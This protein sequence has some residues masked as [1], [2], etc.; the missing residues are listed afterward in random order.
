M[1][2]GDLL[3][4]CILVQALRDL[5][6]P[7]EGVYNATALLEERLA[8]IKVMLDKYQKLPGSRP[9]QLVAVPTGQAQLAVVGQEDVSGPNL[10][11]TVV[12]AI[13][14]ATGGEESEG[15]SFGTDDRK[16]VRNLC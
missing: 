6:D 12:T 4:L 1:V 9:G 3:T 2:G 10:L 13:K 14:N 8:Y 16:Q 7:A 5:A 11:N 15:S